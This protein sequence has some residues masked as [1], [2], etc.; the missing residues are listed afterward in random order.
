M[1]FRLN[2]CALAGAVMLLSFHAGCRGEPVVADPHPGADTEAVEDRPGGEWPRFRGP[3]GMGATEATG[4]P[5]EWSTEAGI[6]WKTPL[7]GAGA[8]SPIVF[9]HHIYLTCYTGYGV[10]GEDGGRLEDLQRSLLCLGRDDGAVLW[11][12][13]VPARQPEES[14]VRDHGYAA[15]TPVAGPDGVFVFHGK[16]GV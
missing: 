3:D 8:S 2:C 11:E 15:S 12:R 4:L 9:G 10:P 6:A 1:T 13:T 7:P 5:L 16:S 14:R